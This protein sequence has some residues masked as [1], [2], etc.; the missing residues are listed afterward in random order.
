MKSAIKK[1]RK[2]SLIAITSFAVLGYLLR[3]LFMPLTLHSDIFYIHVFASKFAYLGVFN[4]YGYIKTNF[5]NTLIKE[6]LNYYPPLAYFLLGIFHAI[7]KIFIPDFGEWINKISLMMSSGIY[8]HYLDIFKIPLPKLG[9]F[10]FVMKAPYLLFDVLCALILISYFNVKEMKLRA[11]KLWLFNPVIIFG[12]YVFGHFDVVLVFF[13]LTSFFLISKTRYYLAMLLLGMSVLLKATPIILIL[14]IGLILG[15]NLSQT[16]KMILVALF[17]ILLATIPFYFLNGNYMV[18]A[19]FPHFL[20]TAGANYI[21]TI[22][23]TIGK[24]IFVLGYLLVFYV[25][26]KKKRTEKHLLLFEDSWKYYLSFILL[27]YFIIFAP[28]HHFQWVVPFLIIAVVKKEISMKLYIFQMFFLFVYAI[29]SKALSSQLLMPIN[30]DY[31]YNLKGL[32]EYI[33]QFFSWAIIMR[34]SRFL[35][36][37]C[38]LFIIYKLIFKPEVKSA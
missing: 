10:I 30:P 32:P 16:I 19:F 36:D 3:I 13:L 15:R 14:P 18:S 23:F 38:C 1:T 2:K 25:L 22:E 9:T 31:F 8:D 21:D 7:F 20:G 28:I 37:F 33:N 35:F 34:L 12:S 26:V 6:G 5:A 27:T 4:I 11:F 17:P 29:N 24:C